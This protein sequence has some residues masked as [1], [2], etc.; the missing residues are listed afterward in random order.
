MLALKQRRLIREV[1]KQVERRSDHTQR[2]LETLLAVFE[3][4]PKASKLVRLIAAAK[5]QFETAVGEAVHHRHLL[6]N[7]DRV[8]LEREYDHASP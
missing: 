2:L 5:P 6:G 7:P 8:M 3:P 4:H 1:V